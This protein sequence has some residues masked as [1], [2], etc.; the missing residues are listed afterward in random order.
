MQNEEELW[1]S[2]FYPNTEVLINNFGIKDFQKLKE[3]EATISFEKLME[4]NQKPLD[5]G[6][7]KK[8][9]LKL[10]EF[11]FG[12]IYPF[13]GKYRKVNISK[14]IG[15]FL[16]IRDDTT[17]DKY[18][19]NLFEQAR[20]NLERCYSKHD[21]AEILAYLYTNLIYCHP[22]R[23]GNGR[24]VREFIREFS[25]KKSLKISEIP[26]E[27]DWR[28]IDKDELNKHLEVAHLYPSQTALLFNKA[29]VP[30]NLN[31]I[32]KKGTR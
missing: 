21:F 12:D 28:L 7:D 5:L 1:N 29:L 3:V 11:I 17:I 23:E 18:L 20:I 14:G 2:Y 4:L 13:A 9:L 24:A 19:D 32:D 25:I 22:F 26:L 10:H 6:L 31:S 16:F 15:T 30:L 8:H 27:L